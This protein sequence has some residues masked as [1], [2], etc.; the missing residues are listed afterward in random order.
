M[1]SQRKGKQLPKGMMAQFERETGKKSTELKYRMQLAE[2]YPT[3]EQV[4][5]GGDDFSSWR[6]FRKSLSAKPE[7]E[8]DA[9]LVECE[10]VIERGLKSF[11]EVGQALA[12]IRDERLYKAEFATFEDYC[13]ARWQLNRAHA[14][15]LVRTSSLSI[16]LDRLGAPSPATES[17]ARELSGLEPGE[18]QEVMQAAHQAT[19]GKI[20]AKAIKQAREEY[21]SEE[22][23]QYPAQ[24]VDEQHFARV[25]AADRQIHELL[26][27]F[28]RNRHPLNQHQHELALMM[29]QSIRAATIHIEEIY[30]GKNFV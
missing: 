11:V 13:Q 1:L 10:A 16:Q 28:I 18:A 2:A 7:P 14:D 20:T 24:P 21:E 4:V 17:Q 23:P 26:N 25:N 9:A 30:G 5:T 15:R 29:L 3:E 22:E 19:N 12:R 27:E 6:E 8:P